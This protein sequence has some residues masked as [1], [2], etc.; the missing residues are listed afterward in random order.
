MDSR[1]WPCPPCEAIRAFVQ[2]PC[3]D[4]HT[5]EGGECP[6]WACADCG[7]AVWIGDAVDCFYVCNPSGSPV[8]PEQRARVD[9]ALVA[10]TVG[11]TVAEGLRKADTP[12]RFR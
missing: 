2:P 10:A 5:D 3:A 12:G 8:E 1:L 4:G 7:H 9:E 6:E 11:P